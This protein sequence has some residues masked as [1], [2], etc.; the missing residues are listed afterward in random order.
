[1]AE[2]VE[3]EFELDSKDAIKKIK[4]LEQEVEN[5]K[6]DV[7]SANKSTEDSLKGVEKQAEGSATG[8]KKVGKSMSSI[9]KAVGIVAILQK[10]FEFVV[11]A[12]KNNQEVMTALSTVFETAQIVFNQVLNAFIGIYKAVTESADNFDALGK[13][14]KGIMTI[15]LTPLKLSFFAIKLAMQEVALGYEKVFGSDE[16]VKKAQEDLNETKQALKDVATEAADAAV[17]IATNVGEAVSEM[18]NIA[19][20][21]KKELG[22]VS[23]T[24]A[25]ETAK[26]NAAL[27]KSA[28]I[29]EAESR[30][31]LERYNTEAELLRQLRDDDRNSIDDRIK[32]NNDL[33]LVL[34][35]Q[36][37]EMLNNV[38]MVEKAA[39]AQFAL[40]GLNEDYIA[41]L[42]AKAEKLGVISAIEGFNSEQKS[43]DMTLQKEQT[44]LTK[45][46]IEAESLLSIEKKRFNAEQITDEVA[47][48]TK[49]Q[50]IDALEKEQETARLQS[51]VD[52]ANAG[53]QAK[54]DAQIA[55]DAFMETSRQTDITRKG[56][57]QTAELERDTKNTEDKIALDKKI[58]DSKKQAFDDLIAIGGAE[59]K[60]GK[61]MLV[62][63]QLLL[64]K[65]LIMDIKS[66]IMTAKTSVTKTT[67]K[68][69]EAGVD[70]A[71]GAAKAASA[72][73]FPANIPLI[74]G[75]AVQAVGIISS[76]KSAIGA[77]KQA[78]SKA[79]GGGGG[80]TNI[81]T[82]SAS[83]GG[84]G[85]APAPPAFNIVGGS[86]TNQLADAIGG[87]SQQPVQAFVVASE[88]TT[89]QSLERNTIASA[90]IG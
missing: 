71:G 28:A 52:N 89:A 74:I 57:I 37:A 29:A 27:R 18:G 53:T 15:A 12:I 8:I 38:A 32:A 33:K 76:I 45:G 51:I 75:Y 31:A 61:A 49:M 10:A 67:V 55:L 24:A 70:V 47:K 77:S 35:K 73:P 54:I 17:Q 7:A 46:Q 65:E 56:E 40:T 20:I 34:A 48:L 81:P 42:N 79:G 62:A 14:I 63:K 21:A 60:F 4:D 3:I 22:K 69:A 85:S 30:M 44:D 68:A 72:L 13:V 16:S 90:T 43:N 36:Q 5:L 26:A 58:S 25:T 1:M 82:P 59:T 88:V 84:A 23:V 87:Q 2:K 41:V 9:L 6:N 78:T 19:S 50:E 11:E 39:Q 86:E 64:A 66:T 83:A 80:G